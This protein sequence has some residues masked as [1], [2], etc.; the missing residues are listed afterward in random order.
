MK[1]RVSNP[2]IVAELRAGGE[3]W[4]TIDRPQKHNALARSTLAA[5]AAAV[6]T[7][8]EADTARFIVVRGAGESYFAAG[9]DLVDLSEVRSVAQTEMMTDEATAALDAIR[10]CR[11]PVL[12]FVNGDAL[13]GGAELA[14][15]CDLRIVASHARIGYVHGRLAITP[16]W[17][18]GTDLCRLVGPSRAMRMMVHGEMIDAK[19]ALAVG[20]V[21]AVVE[22]GAAGAD[23]QA[24]LAPLRQAPPQVLRA[25]KAQVAATRSTPDYTAQRAVERRALVDTWTHP[26]HWMAVER[27]LARP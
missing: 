19:Q 24:F 11:V 3:T 7:H 25:I 10:L 6:A 17:G 22:G 14:L 8:A 4:L 9:G 23:M 15:G 16:A 21:D 27:F 12:A 20:L 5:L 18:G 2:Q 13:G 1:G 26:D